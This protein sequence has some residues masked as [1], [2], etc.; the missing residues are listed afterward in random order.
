MVARYLTENKR[1]TIDVEGA[2]VKELFKNIGAVQEAL[3]AE[4]CCGMPGCGCAKLTFQVRNVDS[5]DFYE[6]VCTKCSARFEFGQH[7]KTKTLFPK[8]RDSG[9]ALPN[10]GWSKYDP[11]K[12]KAAA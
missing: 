7:K 11:N 3:D 5:N 4:Q 6:L 9:K 12:E 1:I 10:G 2:D 8:R